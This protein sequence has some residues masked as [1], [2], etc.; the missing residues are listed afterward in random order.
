MCAGG[1]ETSKK[2]KKL[3]SLFLEKYIEIWICAGYTVQRCVPFTLHIC[4]TFFVETVKW[5][6]NELLVSMIKYDYRYTLHMEN[7]CEYKTNICYNKFNTNFSG[8]KKKTSG[9]SWDSI[10]FWRKFPFP[11]IFLRFSKMY[12][13]QRPGTWVLIFLIWIFPQFDEDFLHFIFPRLFCG[14]M[15]V[16]YLHFQ[17][18]TT[19]VFPRLAKCERCGWFLC[20]LIF[21]FL[22]DFLIR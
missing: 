11:L 8:L 4:E 2:E 14:W 13:C 21:T 19:L 1:C 15:K 5:E 10:R 9:T 3:P 20:T 16:I 17:F 7:G 22:G 12:F 6:N 18:F